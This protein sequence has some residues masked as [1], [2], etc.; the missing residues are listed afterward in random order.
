M[1]PLLRELK[2]TL[3]THEELNPKLWKD[4]KLD[5]EVWAA[6][7]KIAKEWA[8]FANIP[9]RSIKDIILVGGNA[10]YNYTKHSDVDLHLVIDKKGVK[11]DGLVDDYLLSKKQLWALTHDI[12]VKGQPVELYAQ[13]SGDTFKKGQGVYS[14][15]SNRWLQQP[16]RVK[17]D[18]NDRAVKDK[19]NDLSK[20]IN[21]LIDS[22]SNDIGQFRRLKARLKGMRSTAIEKGGEYAPENL[23]FKELRNRGILDRMTKY[24]RDLE[25][26]ELTLEGKT[27]DD[28]KDWP[29]IRKSK[30]QKKP[31]MKW[32]PHMKTFAPNIS[33]GKKKCKDGYE[34]DKDQKRCVRKRPYSTGAYLY[35]GIDHDDDSENGGEG[36]SGGEGGGSGGGE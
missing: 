19:V 35:L 28:P 24:L 32:D 2:S 20:T 31:K 6:L 34:Y 16:E 36:G 25:D 14:L 8:K 22:K 5:P 23:A 3:Q 21:D 18:A 15:K 17:F 7:N 1:K 29:T 4:E 11:C 9:S 26:Q 30:P 13:D 27:S 12:T 10:N 33:E